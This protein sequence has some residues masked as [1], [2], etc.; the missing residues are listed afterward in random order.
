MTGS[1]EE[2]C[3]AAA[4]ALE[5]EPFDEDES[6]SFCGVSRD[7]TGI[8]S[9]GLTFT[10]VAIVG[11]S[12]MKQSGYFSIHGKMFQ[13]RS[14]QL[15]VRRSVSFSSQTLSLDWASSACALK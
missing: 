11:V 2:G 13:S 14:H 4:G 6:H 12:K 5:S 10:I 3:P 8:V 7:G 9:N 1:V 15:R